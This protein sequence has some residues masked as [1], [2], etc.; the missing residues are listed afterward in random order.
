MKFARLA[1]PLLRTQKRC[2]SFNVGSLFERMTYAVPEAGS[3]TIA[4]ASASLQQL[5]HSPAVSDA[6]SH[7][8]VFSLFS[9][10]ETVSEVRLPGNALV[11]HIQPE[12]EQHRRGHRQQRGP[13][14]HDFPA[15]LLRSS[16][17]RG[18]TCSNSSG[19]LP[20]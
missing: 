9:A 6:M 18:I 1:R 11:L 16:L 10:I 13:P 2:I 7:A 4:A 8:P 12:H 20:R 19:S 14:F 15:K 17:R 5:Q 3:G